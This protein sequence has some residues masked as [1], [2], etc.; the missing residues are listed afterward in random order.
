[1]LRQATLLRFYS[2]LPE[3]HLTALK[4]SAMFEWLNAEQCKTRRII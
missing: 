4:D 3:T 1:M 2:E